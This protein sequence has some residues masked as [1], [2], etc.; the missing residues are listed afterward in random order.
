MVKAYFTKNF[1]GNRREHDTETYNTIED[2]I[3][4]WTN[5]K[6][7]EYYFSTNKDDKWTF[8]KHS[9]N[10]SE[11]D[12]INI[13]DDDSIW[14]KTSFDIRVRT[15]DSN[16]LSIDLNRL[17]VN[18]KCWLNHVKNEEES[19]KKNYDVYDYIITNSFMEKVMKPVEQQLRKNN[20]IIYADE[21]EYNSE[22]IDAIKDNKVATSKTSEIIVDGNKY[23]LPNG[24]EAGLINAIRQ[25]VELIKNYNSLVKDFNTLADENEKLR[26]QL[27]SRNHSPNSYS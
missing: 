19:K 7:K 24:I 3:K 6:W 9:S 12:T 16:L 21:P 17:D 11:K 18:G 26:Q 22:E 15:N 13:K 10:S 2:F 1:W 4:E 20:E 14:K 8:L 23:D 25:N 27:N 5:G